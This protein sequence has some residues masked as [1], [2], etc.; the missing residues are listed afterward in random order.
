MLQI[1]SVGLS[2]AILDWDLAH[3]YQKGRLGGQAAK[4]FKA[5]VADSTGSQMLICLIG[6]H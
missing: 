4:H 1:R 6:I 3:R 5:D 2:E